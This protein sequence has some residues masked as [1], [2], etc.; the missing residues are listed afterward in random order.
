MPP[1]VVFRN[2]GAR[3][4]CVP[5][6]STQRELQNK[7]FAMAQSA[8]RS[9][10]RVPP[11][12]PPA[13]TIEKPKVPSHL[14][15]VRLTAGP[16]RQPKLPVAAPAIVQADTTYTVS[17]PATSGAAVIS[18]VAYGNSDSD[19]SSDSDGGCTRTFRDGGGPVG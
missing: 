13:K 2:P 18:L 1:P 10:P 16:A 8:A 5:D 12:L 19:G 11:R 9:V 6:F 14:K 7:G 15:V 4:S 17:A 3:G